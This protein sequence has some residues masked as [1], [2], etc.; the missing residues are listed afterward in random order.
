MI[1][2]PQLADLIRQESQQKARRYFQLALRYAVLGSQPAILVCMGGA[3]TGKSTL[4]ASLSDEL[5][6][7][8]LNSDRIRKQQ[9]GIDPFYRL[10]ESERWLLYDQAVT[11]NVYQEMGSRGLRE[12]LQTGAVI[13][14]A[15]YRDQ[16]N[17]ENLQRICPKKNVRLF[18]IQTE[19]PIELIRQRLKQRETQPSVSDLRISDYVPGQFEITYAIEE[20]VKNGL[21]VNT[22][23]L[24]RDTIDQEII[25]WLIQQA[26][27]ALPVALQSRPS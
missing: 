4:A 25:P 8:I 6:L 22:H 21:K 3:A 19:A 15:T 9:A 26:H 18:V 13:L 7:A 20:Y 11:Q 16:D 5:G 1:S 12:A 24:T 27:P 23:G 17:L 10:P 2:E 14:D